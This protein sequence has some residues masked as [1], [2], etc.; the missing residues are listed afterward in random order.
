MKSVNEHADIIVIGS[1]ACG[2]AAA[3]TAAESNAK[4]IVFEKHRSPGGTSNFF[5][6]TFAVESAMHAGKLHHVQPRPGV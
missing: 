2:L 4:A 1:G 5:E 3:V 6:G